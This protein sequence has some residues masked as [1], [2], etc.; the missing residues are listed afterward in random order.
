MADAR[1][2]DDEF[3]AA[4]QIYWR[5]PASWERLPAADVT[6]PVDGRAIPLGPLVRHLLN[7]TDDPQA[8]SER[9]REAFERQGMR[10]CRT[11]DGCTFLDRLSQP[12]AAWTPDGFVTAMNRVYHVGSGDPSTLPG[13]IPQRTLSVQLDDGYEFPLG[14]LL[15]RLQWQ[16]LWPEHVTPNMREAL[17]AWWLPT[18]EENGRTYI[19]RRARNDLQRD[20]AYLQLMRS[21]VV[22]Y[23]SRGSDF[24]WA[25][26]DASTLIVRMNFDI[27]VRCDVDT[28]GWRIPY[29]QIQAGI[30]AGAASRPT[31]PQLDLANASRRLLRASIINTLTRQVTAYPTSPAPEGIQRMVDHRCG[32]AGLE[33]GRAVLRYENARN[34][35]ASEAG[36]SV[37]RRRAARLESA[38]G[39]GRSG[40]SRAGNAS[41]SRGGE[42]S[43]SPRTR[44]RGSGQPAPRRGP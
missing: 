25:P 15:D 42:R 33:Y 31:A 32:L 34:A 37:V 14:M 9:L 29:D 8:A 44:G 18:T 28:S 21:P 35:A 20:P 4:M 12:H 17:R 43:P 41:R 40:P 30:D 27:P 1:Y 13:Q 22:A 16:G 24:T 6:V 26:M 23:M 36:Q 10:I 39:N 2:S 11:D 5:E 38:A 19:D 7:V 3:I